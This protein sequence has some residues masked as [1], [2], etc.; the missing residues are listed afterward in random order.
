MSEAA[1][2][3]APELEAEASVAASAPPPAHPPGDYAIVEI[4]GHQ[5]LIGRVEEVE[6]F[7]A[8]M[9]RIEPIF[10]G[11][12]LGPVYQAGA[13]LYRFTPCSAEIAFARAPKQVY[14]LPQAVRASQD[15]GA[16]ETLAA[17]AEEKRRAAQTP[18][19]LDERRFMGEASP[20]DDAVAADIED[21]EVEEGPDSQEGAGGAA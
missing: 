12:L 15:P 9:L 19:L 14:S 10:C 20:Y 3:S 11:V 8:K 6:R 17:A 13:S 21:D 18:L 1:A 16:I 5:T 7:G 4:L 2:A